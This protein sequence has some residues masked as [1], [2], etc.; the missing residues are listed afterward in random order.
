LTALC[1]SI[2]KPADEAKWWAAHQRQ[3]VDR[4]EQAKS[5]GKLGKGTV[6]C[7]AR[8]RASHA[9]P[10]PTITIRLA[11]SGLRRARDLAT[12]KG[13]RYQTYVKMLLHLALNSEEKRSGRP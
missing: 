5:S 4:F 8:E 1:C 6:A 7:V 13:L 11:E 10:S 3:I 12:D 2:G 9:G